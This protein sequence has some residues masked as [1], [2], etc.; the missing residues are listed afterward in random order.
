MKQKLENLLEILAK[1]HYSKETILQATLLPTGAKEPAKMIDKLIEL[2]K[3]EMNETNFFKKMEN[4]TAT[5]M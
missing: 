5:M 3:T 4:L 1:N 2:A